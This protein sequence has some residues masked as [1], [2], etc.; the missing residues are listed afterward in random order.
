MALEVIGVG[1]PRTGTASL[2]QA[3]E[4]LGFGRCY[5]MEWLFNHPEEL[6]LWKELFKTGQTD[7]DKLFDGVKSTVDFPGYQNYKAF[8]KQYPD[9]KFVLAERDPEAWYESA[10]NTVYA[11]T[12]KTFSEKFGMLKK[13]IVSARFRKIA[14][15]F[16]L[17]EKYLWDLQYKGNFEDRAATIQIYKEFNEEIKQTIPADQLLIFDISKGWEPLCQFLNVPVPDVKFPV[18]NKRKEFQE[19]MGRMLSTGE[20]LE[21][22]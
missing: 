6:A 9:A 21:L 19:Q 8:Y 17:A 16:Q 14:K 18:K 15:T 13:V 1:G 4:I 10:L 5:H 11:A 12:P 7:F 20:N 2:K 3:L 22:K